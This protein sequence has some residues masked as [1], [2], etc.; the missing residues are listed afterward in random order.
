M[1]DGFAAGVGAVAHVLLPDGWDGPVGGDVVLEGAEGH[2]LARVRRIRAGETVTVADGRGR[3]WLTET[4]GVK[5][6]RVVLRACGPTVTEPQ[7]QPPLTVA[8]ALGKADQP[9]FVVHACTELGADRLVPWVAARSVV[10]PGPGRAEALRA[11]LQRVARAATGQCRRA[12]LPV[13][14]PVTGIEDVAGR[15]GLLV[16]APGGTSPTSLGP[17]PEAGWCLVSGPEGGFDATETRLLA[18]APRVGLGPFV[19]RALTAP[20]VG[21][22]VLRAIGAATVRS[23]GGHDATDPVGEEAE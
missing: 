23:G 22:A 19:L 14:E 13:V 8:F 6:G 9:T 5:A 3:W 20:V 4:A 7:L 1:P 16:A 12:R 2:H 10:R 21:T 11:R 15:P 18:A 17:P